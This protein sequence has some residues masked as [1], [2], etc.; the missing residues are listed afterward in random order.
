MFGNEANQRATISGVDLASRYVVQ[1]LMCS[2]TDCGQPI[3]LSLSETTKPTSPPGEPSFAAATTDTITI[4]FT[5]TGTITITFTKRKNIGEGVMIE[6][7]KIEESA[8]SQ[9]MQQSPAVHR[10]YV[11]HLHNQRS[12]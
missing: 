3:Q 5:T 1:V 9:H 6:K 2:G 7:Y 10:L 12:F 4:T 11:A 8:N